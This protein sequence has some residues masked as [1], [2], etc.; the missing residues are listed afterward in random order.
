MVEERARR[1]IWREGSRAG[2]EEGECW[3]SVWSIVPSY[4][5]PTQRNI[6][7][8]QEKKIYGK[9]CVCGKGEVRN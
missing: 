7:R 9:N 4:S 1:E 8:I 3:C 2:A 5:Q 6:P